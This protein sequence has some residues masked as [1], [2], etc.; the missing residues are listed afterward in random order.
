MDEIT[1]DNSKE[2]REKHMFLTPLLAVERKAFERLSGIRDGKA[3]KCTCIIC[4]S[5]APSGIEP[6]LG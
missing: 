1:C 5:L 4:R 2:I 6:Q 3:K